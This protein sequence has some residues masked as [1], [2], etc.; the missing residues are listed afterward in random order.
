MPTSTIKSRYLQGVRDGA[1]FLFVIGPF[2]L[3]FG[4]VATEAGL[5]VL[6]A[7]AFS[8]MVI[9]GASQFTALQLLVEDAPTFVALASAL[10]VNLRMAM[11]SASMT[12]YLGKLPLWKR[13]IAAYFLVDQ[14]YAVSLMKFERDPEMTPAGRFAY[15]IGAVTPLCPLW[16]L[17]TAIG[18]ILGNAVPDALALDFAVPITFLAIVAPMLRSLPHVA[19]AVVA[20]VLA[21]VFAWLPYNLGLFVAAIAGMMTGAQVEL[22]TQTKA[23]QAKA[24]AE[25]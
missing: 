4:V 1:P 15:F 17:F 24:E 25:T 10:A 8:V 22:M 20:I 19:A 23:A 9:A 3:L 12:P 14:T 7:L 11:Y 6:E 16:Y 13:A 21:L 2:G 5:N 18:A